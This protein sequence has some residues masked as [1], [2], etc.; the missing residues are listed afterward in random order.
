MASPRLSACTRWIAVLACVLLMVTAEAGAQVAAQGRESSVTASLDFNGSSNKWGRVLELDSSIG[1]AFARHFSIDAGV[2]F[3]LY[4]T[5]TTT[6]S[7][8]TASGTQLGDPTVGIHF[9][10][11]NRLLGYNTSVTGT[12][13]TGGTKNG[14]STGH[15]TYDWS[16]HI[17]HA[18]SAFTPFV[19]AGV[20]NSIMDSKLYHHL[21]S[22]YGYNAHFAAGIS[23]DVFK[24]FTVSAAAWDVS[25]WGNQTMFS[26]VPAIPNPDAGQHGR[27]WETASQITG[28]SSLTRDNGYSGGVEASLSRYFD[29]GV[30]YTHSVRYALDTVSFHVGVNYGP[31]GQ[32]K[33]H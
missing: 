3:Y 1:Y 24:L 11:P 21:Y 14:F 18:F 32:A 2:P 10:F 33:S 17:Y 31:G 26:R 27:V 29:V 12:I 15:V 8:G 25:P 28:A 7:N 20:G 5:P 9:N 13:P 22:T 30:G 6:T 19:D 23:K 16:N 4:Q